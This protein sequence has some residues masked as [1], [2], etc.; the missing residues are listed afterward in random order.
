MAKLRLRFSRRERTLAI[1]CA[2]II[3][4]SLLYRYWILPEARRWIGLR[5]EVAA[6]A[7]DYRNMELSLHLR[8]NIEEAYDREKGRIL[9]TGSNTQE[10][11]SLLRTIEGLRSAAAVRITSM[12]PRAVENHDF[13]KVYGANVIVEGGVIPICRFLYMVKTSKKLLKIERLR[14]DALS[15][16]RIKAALLIRR[17][18]V[19]PDKGTV[20]ET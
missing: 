9:A 2:A 19:T 10:L 15:E 11:A 18:L 7:A 1:V 8:S 17:T 4:F 14:L 3:P 6:L 5:S 13:Y 12:T 20:D 16:N